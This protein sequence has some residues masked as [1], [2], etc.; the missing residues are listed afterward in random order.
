MKKHA[1]I[2]LFPALAA[3]LI[4]FARCSPGDTGES[5]LLHYWEKHPASPLDYV[6]AK[7]ASHKWVFLGEHHRVKH[8]VG[9]H[10]GIRWDLVNYGTEEESAREKAKQERYDELMARWLEEDVLLPGRPALVYTGVAHSMAKYDEYYVGQGARQLV[11]MGNMVYTD[12][13]KRDMFFVALHAPFYD[14]GTRADIYPFDGALDRL[15]LSYRKDIGFD[16]KGS[17]FAGLTHKNRSEYSITAYA[18][19]DLYDGYIMFKTPIKDYVGMTCIPEWIST[20]ADFKQYWR[21]LPNKEASIEFSKTPFEEF[22]KTFCSGNPDYG[23]G[24]KRRFRRLPEIE[25][26]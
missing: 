1:L 14:S 16:V 5:A 19:G 3:A 23:E 6:V 4:V 24:F 8:D 2:L 9:L 22:R 7:F 11:R 12:P 18:F 15:M 17:P 10:P 26:R 21:N 20:E 25:S 13:Y